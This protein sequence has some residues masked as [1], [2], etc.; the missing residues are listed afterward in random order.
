MALSD[1]VFNYCER[2]QD[3]GIWAEPLN[4]LTNGGFLLAAVVALGLLL[5]RPAAA[6]SADHYLLI[7]LV[8]I[9]GLGSL[10]FHLFATKGTGLADTIPI[11]L[12]MLIYLAFALNRFLQVPPGWTTLLVIAFAAAG[13][14]A[15]QL[16]CFAGG[17]GF[18]GEGVDS[19]TCLNGSVGYLPALLAMLIV[20][21][22]VWAR[23]LAAG[24]FILWAALVF[25][26][27]VTFRSLD[28][29]LCDT[30]VFD[31][32]RVGTHVV[33][34]LLNAVTLFLLLLASFRAGEA[35]PLSDRLD[36]RDAEGK[37][38]L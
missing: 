24:R 29:V 21:G 11:G 27:S 20:G 7:G 14:G 16:R 35:A 28:M 3:P 2:G 15:M 36:R 4:A 17:I 8:F 37:T 19:G 5:R 34:H 26:V 30:L 33:W 31:G 6:R 1:H 25:A 23:G 9:I 32:H 38:L 12:F 10:A 18:P 13:A 22:L